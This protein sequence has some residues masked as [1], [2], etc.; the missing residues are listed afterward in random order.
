MYEIIYIPNFRK[1]VTQEH[2]G[3]F[4]QMTVEHGIVQEIPNNDIVDHVASHSSLLKREL[5]PQ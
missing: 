3:A 5:L 1:I 4:V 2:T